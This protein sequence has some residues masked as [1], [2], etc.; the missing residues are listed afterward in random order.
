MPR[1]EDYALIGDLQTAAL[2]SHEGSVDWACF[3]RFDS[4]ACFAALLGGSEHGRWQIAPS[5]G[6][7]RSERRYRHDTLVLETYLEADEGAVRLIDFMPPRGKAPDIVRIIEGVRGRVPMRSELVIRYDYGTIVPWVQRV[8]DTRIAIA[9]P[10]ALCFRTPIDVHGENMTTVGDFAVAAGDR[11]PFVLTWFP[12]HEQIP[13]EVDAEQALRDTVEYWNDWAARCDHAGS[14]H[15]DVHS[16]LLVLKALTYAPTGGIV[17]AP[18][19]SL[20]EQIGG[21]R[22]WDYRFCWLRDATL[23]LVAMLNAGYKDEA[24]AWRD[25]LLRAVAGDPADL[26]IMYGLAGER[27]LDERELDWLP[28]YEGSRPVRVGNEASEQLQLDVYGEVLDAL[29]EARLHGARP[30]PPAWSIVRAMVTWL[31]DGWQLED[32][33]IWE[34][35]GP[36]RHFTHSKVMAWVA[37][38]R[39]C[40]FIEHFGWE[41]PLDRWRAVREQVRAEVLERAYDAER[42]TFTQSYGSRELDAS[43]LLMPFVGF[44]PADDERMVGTVEAIRE[45][46]TVDGLV[47]RYDDSKTAHRGVRP[48][49]EAPARELPAGAHAPCGRQHG[50]HLRARPRTAAAGARHDVSPGVRPS[51]A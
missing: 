19:T 24:I 45:E 36:P 4:G 1:I 17:A 42:R 48:G 10:D 43:V 28:G 51:C 40:R 33:G 21:V 5:S 23:T 46:L 47:R 31:E 26:Q 7:R 14:Y 27:R 2:V 49:R 29:F 44:L 25:W 18:T 37:F 34:V 41:G 50:F 6:I 22:N 12:S 11:V 35:R 15:Q 3:P 8:D 32:S 16:S 38:D 9:G 39:G 13:E 20:P 30:S